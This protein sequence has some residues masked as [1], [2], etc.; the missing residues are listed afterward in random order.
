MNYWERALPVQEIL[1]GSLAPDTPHI[2]YQ[3]FGYTETRAEGSVCL[4]RRGIFGR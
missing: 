1:A 4:D 2:V 3:L